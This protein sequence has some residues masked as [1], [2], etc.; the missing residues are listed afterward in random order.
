MNRVLKENKNEPVSV[1]Y[2]HMVTKHWSMNQ[3]HFHDHYEINFA[4]SGGNQ[5]FIND[6]SYMAQAGD[7]FFF[8]E[9]DINRNIVPDRDTYERYL[10]I[11]SITL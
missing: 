3:S 9:K 1:I 7:L 8:S 5:F 11:F 6:R 4:I 10:V 2:R